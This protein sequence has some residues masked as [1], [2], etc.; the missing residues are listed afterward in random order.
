[1]EDAVQKDQ[2]TFFTWHLMGIQKPED[3]RS[4]VDIHDDLVALG[5]GREA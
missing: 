1:V 5:A 2:M 4:A 3:R